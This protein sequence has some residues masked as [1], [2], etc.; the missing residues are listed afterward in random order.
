MGRP[1]MNPE[2]RR[3]RKVTVRVKADHYERLLRQARRDGLTIS[4]YILRCLEAYE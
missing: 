2:Q 1:P 4:D 3:S